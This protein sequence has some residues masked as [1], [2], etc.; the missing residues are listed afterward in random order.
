MSALLPAR[1]ACRGLAACLL[2]SLGAAGCASSAA[3][4][5]AH[6]AERRQDYD[7]AVVEYTKALRQHPD[8]TEAR[9]ALERA[10][11]RASQDH[12]NRGRR[13]AALGKF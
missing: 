12:F 2:L 1:S 11:L 3:L 8:N 10:K 13:F 5:H 9:L 7:L 4:G 6:D